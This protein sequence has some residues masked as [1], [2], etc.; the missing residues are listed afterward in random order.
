MH[1]KTPYLH[2]PLKYKVIVFIFVLVLIFA[3]MLFKTVHY[4]N[5][6]FYLHNMKMAENSTKTVSFEIDKIILHK[7]QLIKTFFED[8][9]DI[10]TSIVTNPD[11][12]NTYE[13]LNKKLERYFTDYFATNIIDDKGRLIIDE[14]EGSIGKLCLTDI[15][16]YLK[17]HKQLIRLH[18]NPIVFHYD[19]IYEFTINSKKYIFLVTFTVDEI[20]NLLNISKREHH[21]LFIIN[22]KI[23]K[24][25]EITDKA[26]RQQLHNRQG[27]YLSNDEDNRI[28]S[29]SDI[30]D[31]YWEVVDFYDKFLLTANINICS[32]FSISNNYVHSYYNWS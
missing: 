8:N 5:D 20:V 13:L 31:T 24:L 12:Y 30:T 22:K 18:P 17:S 21:S 11:N 23:K 28:V 27:I 9:E 19:I 3:S 32:L 2:I 1:K 6:E 15:S 14:F 29:R 25:I 26:S 10:I 7:K 16:D 4:R